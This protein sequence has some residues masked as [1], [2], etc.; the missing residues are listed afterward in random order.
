MFRVISVALTSGLPSTV[1]AQNIPATDPVFC[2]TRKNH[3]DCFAMLCDAAGQRDWLVNWIQVPHT[4][5]VL[6]QCDSRAAVL[7]DCTVD[8]YHV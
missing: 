4:H 2:A 6:L 3:R 7:C 1:H 5:V 8:E